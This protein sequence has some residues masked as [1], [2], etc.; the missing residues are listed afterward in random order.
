MILY[1]GINGGDWLPYSIVI[2]YQS[3]Y[4]NILEY[5]SISN[6][7]GHITVCKHL[8]WDKVNINLVGIGSGA[9]FGVLLVNLKN[10]K[11]IMATKITKLKQSIG[12]QIKAI[13]VSAGLNQMDFAI[14]MGI[15]PAHVS[16]WETG[17]TMPDSKYLEKICDEFWVELRFI[18][19]NTVLNLEN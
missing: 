6:G 2:Q 5:Y 17:R 15:T 3:N 10:S 4:N 11:Q 19:R 9:I 14:K 1:S 12:A 7:D 8:I 18:S 13:R 16:Y